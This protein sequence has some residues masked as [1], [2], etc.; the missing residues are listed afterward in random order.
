MLASASSVS[1]RPFGDRPHRD[2][3]PRRSVV[4]VKPC[5]HTLSTNSGH[6]RRNYR[7]TPLRVGE[8]PTPHRIVVERDADRA[9]PRRRDRRHPSRRT[10]R[11]QAQRLDATGAAPPALA[12]GSAV[13]IAC[14]RDARHR[15]P[16]LHRRPRGPATV[17][18]HRRRDGRQRH[19]A[20]AAARVRTTRARGLRDRS[21]PTCSGASA[22]AIPTKTMEHYPAL[23]HADGLADIVECHRLA[24]RDRRDRRSASPAS[25]WAAATRTSRRSPATSTPRS[26]STAAA[27]R[28][29]SAPRS[30][31]CSRSSADT[32]SGS[33]ATRSRKS[34][35]HHPGDVIVYEDAEHGFMRDGSDNYH[36]TAAPDA[37]AR[38]LAFFAQHLQEH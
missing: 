31:R 4:H 35:Q 30:A 34:K 7:R 2:R 11:A 5:G 25:A 38:M 12:A 10:A 26:R 13:G 32:T 29:I 23:K 28:N 8:R 37:W 3:S 18:R 1:S 27:S 24:A 17:A 6:H 20:P 16:V 21:R 15:R 14:A 33:R 22:A 36:E 19:L 9:R